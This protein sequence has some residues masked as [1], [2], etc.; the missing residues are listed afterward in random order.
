MKLPLLVV[1]LFL[2]NSISVSAGIT[3]WNFPT[4]NFR[5]QLEQSTRFADYQLSFSDI[6]A[7]ENGTDGSFTITVTTAGSLTVTDTVTVTYTVEGKAQIGVDYV[8]FPLTVKIPVAAGSGS[9]TIPVHA[10]DDRIMEYT[11]VIIFK[12]QS[13]IAQSGTTVDL[14]DRPASVAIQDDDEGKLITFKGK[15]D[16]IE[17][18]EYATVTVGIEGDYLASEPITV[19]AS[20]SGTA[21]G[22]DLDEPTLVIP[23]GQNSVTVPI[24]IADDYKTEG[25]EYIILDIFD[26]YGAEDNYFYYVAHGRDTI[27]IFDNDSIPVARGVVRLIGNGSAYSSTEGSADNPGNFFLRFENLGSLPIS[28]PITV[29]LTTKGP[30][31]NGIDYTMPQTVIVPVTDTMYNWVNV[32]VPALNDNIIEGNEFVEVHI[33]NVTI[34]P[35]ATIDYYIN[36]AVYISIIDDDSANITIAGSANGK[37]GGTQGSI[38]LSYSDDLVAAEDVQVDYHIDPS[39]TTATQG[40]D[41]TIPADVIIPAGQHST[42]IPITIIDDNAV[43]DTEYVKIVTDSAYGNNLHYPVGPVT[44]TVVSIADNDRAPTHCGPNRLVIP[45]V[46]TPNGDGRDDKFV[47]RGLEQYPNSKLFIYNLLRGGT[48]VYQSKDYKNDWDGQGCYQGLYS[49]ILEVNEDGR[50]KIYKGPL[51]IIR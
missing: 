44:D 15:T 41:F 38:T 36:D 27:Y 23:E 14:P 4:A 34:P 51:V 3:S 43:E 6:T 11:E 49:Y 24:Y 7:R 28:E 19:A 2:C 33:S 32:P 10:I 21:G 50:V 22:Y 13:A 46:I 39:G 18:G 35:G 25:T 30:A 42:T 48:L 29:S 45:N 16:G 12:F 1:L 37:E 40:T 17:G 5:H 31:T 9:V 26:A 8:P 20:A 47:I